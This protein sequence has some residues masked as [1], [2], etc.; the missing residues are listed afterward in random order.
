M[1]GMR[2][3]DRRTSADDHSINH[4]HMR[5]PEPTSAR[6]LKQLLSNVRSQRDVAKD[7]VIEK[8][9]QLEESQRLYQEQREKLESTLVLYQETQGQASSYL[10][11]YTEEKARSSELEIQYNEVQQESQNYLLPVR[12]FLRRFPRFWPEPSVNTHWE[13]ESL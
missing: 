11:L 2:R 8:E 6:E 9:Q 10:S 12:S 4:P 5:Q 1:A 13:V 7:Q 3:A